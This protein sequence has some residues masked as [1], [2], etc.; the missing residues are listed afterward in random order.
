VFKVE[1]DIILKRSIQTS[2]A[3]TLL[4]TKLL[5]QQTTLPSCNL[6]SGAIVFTLIQVL[7]VYSYA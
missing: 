6:S 5:L 3:V 2:V 4:Q 1:L 7:C